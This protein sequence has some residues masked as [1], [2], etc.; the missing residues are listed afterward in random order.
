MRRF[1][2][3]EDL[4]RLKLSIS[5][6][7]LVIISY[8]VQLSLMSLL[9]L[10]HPAFNLFDLCLKLFFFGLKFL[11]SVF[12]VLINLMH[13]LLEIV[14]VGLVEFKVFVF[15]FDL[16]TDVVCVLIH[17]LILSKHQY[18]PLIHILLLTIGNLLLWV[19][20][21]TWNQQRTNVI[22]MVEERIAWVGITV[23]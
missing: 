16:W 3:I 23:V 6:R 15:I 21:R 11:I 17:Y 7:A 9:T 12:K 4:F 14:P 8:H 5:L 19:L 18:L 2:M 13:L 1:L 22:H 20:I 10:F